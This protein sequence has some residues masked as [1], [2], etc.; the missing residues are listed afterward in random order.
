MYYKEK[1]FKK[2][3]AMGKFLR[4][5]IVA[6]LVSMV[7][8]GCGG[9]SSSTV[10]G[11]NG[12][13]GTGANGAGTKGPFVKGSTVTAYKLDTNGTKSTID[14]NSTVTTDDLGNYDLSSI[15]WSGPTQI[16]ISGNYFNE[17]NGTI[18]AT[19]ISLSCIVKIVSGQ[20]VHA[21]IN[22]FTDLEAQRI[23]YLMAHGSSYADAKA[24]AQA[25]IVDLFDLN[26]TSGTNLEDLNP[27]DGSEHSQPN[28]ELL[29]VSSALTVDPSILDGLREGILDGNMTNDSLGKGSFVR[30]GNLVDNVDLNASSHNLEADLNVSDAPDANDTTTSATYV[31][32]DG[33][34][35][36]VLD[37][38]A[39]V[40]IDEDSGLHAIELNATD[41]DG[42]TLTYSAIA[43]PEG[44]LISD[45]NVSGN[46]LSIVPKPN[47]N[48][49]FTVTAFVEDNTSLETS[50]TFTVTVNPVNDAP[51]AS[52]DNITI[53]EDTNT[54][55]DV[56]ANDTDAEGDSLI[57]SIV[58]VPFSGSVN[59]VN[60]GLNVEYIPTANYAGNDLFTY[61]VSDGHG[62]ED[63]ASVT[64]HITP[65]NDAPVAN[66]DNATTN[67]DTAKTIDVLTNDTDV[68]RDSLSVFDVTQPSHGHVAIGN[69]SLNV[70]YTPNANYNGMDSFSYTVSDGHN[71]TD[72]ATV[73]MTIT[74]VND[75][76]IA[77]ADANT[78]AE[79]TQITTNVVANDT[80]ADGDTLSIIG[81]PTATN[82]TVSISGTTDLVFT[83]TANFNGT[84]TVNYTVTDGTLTD[85][86]T[87]T[88]TITPV[89]DAPVVNEGLENI[90]KFGGDI[91]DSDI[92]PNAF[93]DVDANTTLT[94]TATGLEGTGVSMSTSGH[95]SGTVNNA[96][97]DYNVTVTASDGELSVSDTFTVTVYYTPQASDVNNTAWVLANGNKVVFYPDKYFAV[98]GVDGNSSFWDDGVWDINDS[99]HAIQLI[100][101]DGSTD[102]LYL[103]HS[104][105]AIGDLVT[106]RFMDPNQPLDERSTFV[107]QNAIDITGTPQDIL[108]HNGPITSDDVNSTAIR[109]VDGP[110]VYLY[111]DG[112]SEIIDNED[113]N[114]SLSYSGGLWTVQNNNLEL[115]D[116]SGN[117]EINV[118]F[119]QSSINE[120]S[121]GYYEKA[122][123]SGFLTVQD[124]IDINKTDPRINP[125]PLIASDISRKAIVFANHSMA[126][127]FYDIN[128][129]N[130]GKY[131]LKGRD[132][133][134]VIKTTGVYEL[135]TTNGSVNLLS[136][137]GDFSILTFNSS[138]KKGTLILSYDPNSD[139]YNPLII[140]EIFGF[141]D[142][143][144]T[145]FT[146]RA[147]SLNSSNFEDKVLEFTNQKTIVF[148]K[149]GLFEEHGLSEPNQKFYTEY[150]RW[151]KEYD[152]V[153]LNYL[154]DE[155]TDYYIKFNVTPIDKGTRSSTFS[156][157]TNP[158]SVVHTGI[159]KNIFDLV[160]SIA[161]DTYPQ[162]E[163]Q[164]STSFD[165]TING[166]SYTV[167]VYS[168]TDI[169]NASDTSNNLSIQFYG[170]GPIG[171]SVSNSF[172]SLV[173]KVYKNNTTFVGSFGPFNPSDGLDLGNNPFSR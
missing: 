119:A 98:V 111:A 49:V 2:G 105:P 32:R 170:T 161:V 53:N 62:G 140:R 141:G 70:I 44:L 151:S 143:I 36:P 156:S 165:I 127:H 10:G 115:L 41:E 14:V 132:D 95:F 18:S 145:D 106:D 33:N 9:G 59:I 20:S 43:S 146:D 38:I 160:P 163:Y 39:D 78:I 48:G 51:V 99:M 82:G 71:G 63:N 27:T 110:V 96:P 37:T 118:S 137:S 47:Q 75:A 26:M 79:D 107:I 109:I 154:N 116:G 171:F 72:T 103:P 158:Y 13:G 102:L 46:V 87:W 3:Y 5:V 45:V 139:T 17:N 83:P 164:A 112:T 168:N 92:N 130:Q 52:D 8:V 169:P 128:D 58:S 108:N 76:P 7:L 90:T 117:S 84:A 69:G 89:N 114:I 15:T 126:M 29:R 101:S 57:V 144:S 50:R 147:A 74:P 131:W 159:V 80:D 16:V 148:F 149:D 55:I 12:T 150:G 172:T 94:Y 68:D 129:S 64:V 54:T 60:G 152:S 6:I 73:T 1:F 121:L 65:V 104:G 85:T 19:P 135:N 91:I 30:L 142:N 11:T 88:I 4:Y 113:Q 23:I 93:S 77:V 122:N 42:G 67:E 35:A 173:L 28:A 31:I 24:Q 125:Y 136:D 123:D 153:K 133:T 40:T 56:L 61:T 81:T 21:N 22:V 138:P 167:R 166:I 124:V 97:G 134:G 155:S 66:D 100:S 34:H 157:R 86:A 162:Y 120:G 25:G